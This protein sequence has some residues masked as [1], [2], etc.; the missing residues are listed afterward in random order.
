[1]TA[2]NLLTAWTS[3]SWVQELLSR[4][5]RHQLV[6]FQRPDVR[7]LDPRAPLLTPPSSLVLCLILRTLREWVLVLVASLPLPLQPQTG[8]RAEVLVVSLLG[9]EPYAI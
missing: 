4:E 8:A 3:I 6:G 9:A 1:M 5:P 2:L 7:V